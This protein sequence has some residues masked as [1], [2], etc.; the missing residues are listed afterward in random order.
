MELSLM[1]IL[2][3]IVLAALLIPWYEGVLKD[4]RALIIAA[5][6]VCAAFLLRVPLLSWR[7]GD[8][9]SFLVHWVQYFRDNG[10]F[11]AFRDS[12]GSGSIN[13]NVPYLYFL[14]IFSY[15]PQRDLFLI[16]LLSIT[17]DVVL[18]YAVM[19]LVSVYTDS[20]AKKLA[21]YLLTLLLPT[22]I[23]NGAQWGQCDSIYTAFLVL[24]LYHVLTGAPR[25]SMA[26]A[27]LALGFKLQAV[28]LLPVF[29]VMLFAKKL[30]WRDVLVFPLTY[31]LLLLPAVLGG[32]DFISVLTFY[33]HSTGTIGD[34]LNYNSPSLFTLISPGEDSRTWA[35]MG[36]AAAFLYMLALWAWSWYRRKNLSNEALLG[37]SILF[38]VGIPLL[39]PH[40]HDRYFFL[41]DVLTLVPAVLWLSY[42]PAAVLAT[43]AS[44]LCYHWYL[45]GSY[46]LPPQYGTFALLGV[47]LI[48]FG[49]TAQRI[50]S[51][52]YPE[53][54]DEKIR[55]S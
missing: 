33:L 37:L 6:V 28:F 34:G 15:L 13:Y 12:T 31:V 47:L 32:A 18:A 39:L 22:V 44:Y 1:I 20:G 36:I 54:L 51:N 45:N 38:A 30:R 27:A 21:A 42:I 43:L 7:S 24:S 53:P 2:A 55:E 3:L 25:R 10:G 46:P 26:E 48:F 19:K 23:L 4:G 52:R 49:F 50:G 8:Y 17:F 41:S 5:A 14:A 11:A 29:L 40:M 16:K 35:A 9:N